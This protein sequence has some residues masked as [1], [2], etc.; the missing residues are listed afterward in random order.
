M[1]SPLSLNTDVLIVYFFKLRLDDPFVDACEYIEN[2]FF[3]RNYS[4]RLFPLS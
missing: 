2:L 1:A 3:S 4:D